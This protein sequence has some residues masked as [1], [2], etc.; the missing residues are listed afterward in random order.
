MFQLP[1]ASVAFEEDNRTVFHLLKGFLVN[2]VG[3]PWIKPF[4]GTENGC[5]ASWAWANH[6]N[7]EGK[8]S[9]CT[10]LAKVH[11]KMLYYKQEQSL[12][13]KRFTNILMKAYLMLDKD[14]DERL[15]D[16]EKIQALLE[17]IKVT[18]PWLVV[19]KTVISSKWLF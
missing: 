8:L 13:F 19:G 16:C 15:S 18:E 10:Q 17:G 7:G 2:T 14:P 6:Y 12:P 11:I 9:K 3:D 5:D 4:E 1:L